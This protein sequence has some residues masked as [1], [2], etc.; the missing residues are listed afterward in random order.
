[1]SKT[2]EGRK[3]IFCDFEVFAN[4]IHPVTN[5]AYWMVVFIEYN[6]KK[7]FTIKNDTAK[8]RWFYSHYK[9]HIF[10][11]YNIRGYDQWVMKGAILGQDT[12]HITKQIIEHGKKGYHVV[13]NNYSVP[14][15]IYDV[16]TG[17]HGLKQLEAFMGSK[18]KESEVPFDLD[19][20]LTLEEEIEVEE[21]CT[22]DVEQTIL[23]FDK[24][25]NKFDA[26]VGLLD[27]F[28]LDI[29]LISKTTAQ[30]TAEILEAKKV[31]NKNDEFEFIYP[32]TYKIEKYTQVKEFFDS[33]KNGTFVATSFEKGKPKIEMITLIAGTETTYA[34]GGLHAAIPNFIYE[35]KIYSLDVASLYPALILEYGLMSRACE[36][37]EKFR[38]IRD[39]RIVLKRAKNPL[40]EALKL[41]INTV[42][43]T[44]G[45][46]YNPLCDKRMMRSVCV[47][48]QLL[49]T[50]FIEKI[51]N[52]CTLFNLNTDGVFFYIENDED[53]S[54]MKA[55]MEAKAEW[56]KRTRLVL[57]LEEYRKVVQKDVNNYIV[58]PDGDLY[59]KDGKPRWKAKGA[60]V[61]KLNDID[62]DLPI[63]N[64]AINNYFLKN[65]PV[66]ETINECNDLRDF[67]KV[68]K[69]T[70]A[71]DYALKDCT[72]TETKVINPETGKKVN[73]SV[74]NEDGIIMKDKTFRVFASTKESDGGIFKQKIGKN[75]EKFANTPDKCFIDNDYV[76]GKEVPDYLDRQHYID[77]AQKRVN[78]FLGIKNKPT[79]KKK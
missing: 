27:M 69:L 22:H 59:D 48:G 73:K 9:D 42:Y 3:L 38:Y 16:A 43:G 21:Y 30:V 74:Y 32:D 67:Q 24:L 78:Q 17:F 25:K 14:L 40:Q 75:P 41:A 34:L 45:D 31:D 26:Q 10:V 79:R 2:L 58:V 15:N 7:K 4:S 33:V 1:M 51:E 76:L 52:Y 8:L 39:E 19:R 36:S 66:E 28:D 55:I 56:E 20:P 62:Y 71:Y 63:V 77:M 37:D 11:G 29:S 6:S 12:G 5:Q 50:D 61:K 35:G 13:K 44:F 60:Y 46:Q 23:V 18:I 57:E 64:F 68:I 70:S 54:K 47:A 65:K 49:L 72:F 53:G